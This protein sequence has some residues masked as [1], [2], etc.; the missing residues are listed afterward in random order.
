MVDIVFR[1]GL[2][3]YHEHRTIVLRWTALTSGYANGECLE[4]TQQ[5][6]LWSRISNTSLTTMLHLIQLLA[7]VVQYLFRS[8]RTTKFNFFV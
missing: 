7:I 5:S 3:V 8:S 6:D 4:I 2:R 1:I